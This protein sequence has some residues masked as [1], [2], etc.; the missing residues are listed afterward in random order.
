MTVNANLTIINSV[1]QFASERSGFQMH[2]RTLNVTNSIFKCAPGNESFGYMFSA[3]RGYLYIRNSTYSNVGSRDSDFY[4]MLFEI[5]TNYGKNLNVSIDSMF[6]GMYVVNSHNITITETIVHSDMLAFYVQNSQN[7]TID[8]ALFY[9]E[10][11]T[12]IKLFNCKDIRLI[13]SNFTVT[14]GTIWDA[15]KYSE[16]YLVENITIDS[17]NFINSPFKL[18]NSYCIICIVI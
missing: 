14:A 13:N 4:A 6:V 5:E 15:K 7:I 9:T 16:L 17:C 11:E 18:R 10:D 12:A 1:I 3:N 8:E 2:A